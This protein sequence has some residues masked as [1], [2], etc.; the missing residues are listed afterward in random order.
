MDLSTLAIV[1][2][3][4]VC[5]ES[6]NSF[7]KSFISSIN[8]S[9]IYFTMARL[10]SRSQSGANLAHPI[11]QSGKEFNLAQSG[12]YIFSHNL[13][14]WQTPFYTKIR[15]VDQSGRLRNLVPCLPTI[16]ECELLHNWPNLARLS[17]WQSGR[18]PNLANLVHNPT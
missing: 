1:D 6:D 11:W 4:D 17:I 5:S 14:I 3:I 15:C 12:R 18:S 2:V 10:A 8:F 7:C 9:S 13:A 16:A